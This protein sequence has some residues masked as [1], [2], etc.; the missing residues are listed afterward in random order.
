MANVD[1]AFGLVP[2]GNMM[3]AP[4]NGGTLKCVIAAGDGTAT[5]IG[6]PVRLVGSG[7]SGTDGATYPT[8]I[9]G[10]RDA[11]FFGVV[12]SFEAD[13]DN[14]SNQ[15]RLASTERRC[16]VVPALPGQL[17]IVQAYE[18]IVV[19]DIG[20]FFDFTVSGG[21]VLQ[22][23]STVTGL[24]GVELDSSANASSEAN[25]VLLGVYNAPDNDLDTNNPIVII[26][27][28]ESSLYSGGTEV[29]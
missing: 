8:V 22:G 5:F 29:S 15:Y 28:N 10:T 4:Y 9:V 18:D 12:T 11:N 6:D 3:G 16:N 19:A 7:I 2:I 26:R 23:G 27:L 25:A 17:F 13:A 24:S 1:A 14:L 20:L 21:E